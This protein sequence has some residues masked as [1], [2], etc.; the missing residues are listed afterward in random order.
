[1]G[2]SSGDALRQQMQVKSFTTWVNLHLGRVNMEVS[3]LRTDFAD[4]V[5][6]INLIEVISEDSLG[7]YHKKCITKFQKV[8]NLNIPLKFINEF[9]KSQGIKNQYSA[10]NILAEDEVLILGMIWSIIRRFAVEEISE[11]DRTAKE[12]LLLWAQ[13]KVE[14]GSKGKFTVNNF[15]SSWQDG[16]AF[17]CGAVPEPASQ[18]PVAPAFRAA[19]LTPCPPR[20]LAALSF[21]RCGRT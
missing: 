16:T 4:G 1:M 18:L 5:K 14:E 11:G 19:P 9:I 15:H 10:E 3:D 12:G 6:L 2:D 8:E 13:K 7:K 21:K 17:W 20:R